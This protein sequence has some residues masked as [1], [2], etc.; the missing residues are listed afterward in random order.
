MRL[1]LPD[2]GAGQAFRSARVG[3]GEDAPPCEPTG[4]EKFMGLQANHPPFPDIR[5]PLKTAAR[6][7]QSHPGCMR[8]RERE[9]SSS[10][11]QE[12]W[13]I[14]SISGDPQPPTQKPSY[15]SPTLAPSSIVVVASLYDEPSTPGDFSHFSPPSSGQSGR[16]Y[17]CVRRPDDKPHTVAL[18]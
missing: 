4:Q 12:R 3:D 13:N 16:N 1:R 2:F 5:P 10:Q 7:Y 9:R 18:T 8:R 14:F 15:A 17:G 6:R 11:L